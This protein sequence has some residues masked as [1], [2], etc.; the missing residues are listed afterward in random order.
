MSDQLMR[1]PRCK[2]CKKMYKVGSA[3]AHTNSG[4]VEVTCPMCNGIGK[5]QTLNQ[6]LK[7]I[8][9][10]KEDLKKRRKRA[11]PVNEI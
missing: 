8:T 11:S 7:E 2:G 1:C 4:G 9:H 6:A 5:A 10:G 3:Y